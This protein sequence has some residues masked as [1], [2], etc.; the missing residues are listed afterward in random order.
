LRP[1]VVLTKEIVFKH[2]R[3]GSGA[4]RASFFHEEV[5][6]AT[7]AQTAPLAGTSQLA[8]TAKNFERVRNSCVELAINKDNIFLKGLELAASA[9]W[10]KWMVIPFP[11]VSERGVAGVALRVVAQPWQHGFLV[12]SVARKI[13]PMFPNGKTWSPPTAGTTNGHS[14]SGRCDSERWR[15][16]KTR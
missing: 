6:D 9:T 7:I 2:D 15:P 3:Q 12:Y 13:F 10:V 4:I 1:E 8:L 16:P 5:C 11:T 14:R